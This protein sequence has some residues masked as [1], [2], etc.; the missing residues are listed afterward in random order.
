MNYD[1]IFM[2]EKITNKDESAGWRMVNS[3]ADLRFHL[4]A[5]NKL[6]T[7]EIL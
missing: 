4:T 5:K 3:F 7:H 6:Y 2:V 1:E